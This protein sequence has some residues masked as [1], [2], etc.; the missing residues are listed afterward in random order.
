[1]KIVTNKD[2]KLV[3]EI[4]EKIKANDGHCACAI[5]QT[6][7]NKCMCKEFRDKIDRKEIGYC[8]CGLYKIESVD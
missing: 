2:K 5:V 7:D 1:M 4:R 6:P 3:E 8:H